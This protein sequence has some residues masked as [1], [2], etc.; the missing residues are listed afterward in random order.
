MATILEKIIATKREEIAQAK[1]AIP[2]E[3]LR[4]QI[5]E[6]PPLRNF[7]DALADADGIALIAE[8]K[9]ASPSAGVIRED[10]DPQQIAKIYCLH[11]A[12]CLSVLTDRNFFQGSLEYLAQ[13][14]SVVNVPILRKDFILDE[15]QLL[16]ARIAGADAVLL[17]AECLNDCELRSLYQATINLQMTPLVELY[18]E[19]NLTRVLELGATLIG[20]NNR[21]LHDFSINLDHVLDLRKDMPTKCLVVG[22]SGICTREDVLR[23]QKGNIDAIL[24]GETLMRSK[25]IG[26][27]VDTLLGN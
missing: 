1:R 16:E 11:G 8:I 27:A 4:A 13:V 5:S 24:V 2:V 10:F 26:V 9:K 21:N 15:Y 23:L 22:E 3:Q 6:A 25:D 20:V 17:I 7:F 12:N 18:D 14:R 19:S